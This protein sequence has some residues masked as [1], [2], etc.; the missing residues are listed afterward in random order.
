MPNDNLQVSR[1]YCMPAWFSPEHQFYHF[2]GVSFVDSASDWYAASNYLCN[3]LQFLSTKDNSIPE[4]SFCHIAFHG[5]FYCMMTSSNGDIFRVTGPLWGNS[6]VP[7]NSPHKGQWRGALMF[8]LICV[9]INGWANN[10]EAGDLRRYR[11]H[12]NVIVMGETRAIVQR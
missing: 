7:V 11:G 2:Y 1:G 4:L 9:W 8:P 3:S 6:P 10:R 12:Y 5:S